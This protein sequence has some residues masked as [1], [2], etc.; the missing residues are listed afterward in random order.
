[1]ALVEWSGILNRERD[2]L[3]ARLNRARTIDEEGKV[4]FEEEPFFE[5][6]VG[7]LEPALTFPEEVPEIEARRAVGTALFAGETE[8]LDAE[9][10]KQVVEEQVVAFLASDPRPYVLVGSVSAR[11]FEGL[12]ETEIAGC[13]VTFHSRAPEAFREGHRRAENRVRGLVP[14][15]YGPA[16]STTCTTPPSPSSPKDALKP[17]QPRER[18]GPSTCKGASGT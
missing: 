3:V 7:V 5:D 13:R 6:V 16:A 8:V 11:Y 14:G 1:M 9:T 2:E 17:T 15:D 4:H 12:E 10:F 18:S